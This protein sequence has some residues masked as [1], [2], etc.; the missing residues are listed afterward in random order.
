M[1]VARDEF[2][3]EY[4]VPRIISNKDYPDFFGL[5]LVE[6]DQVSDIS[7]CVPNLDHIHCLLFNVL[8]SICAL[9]TFPLTLVDFWLLIVAG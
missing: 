7:G 6:P 3:S 9:R 4:S 1:D 8:F 5:G 2:V